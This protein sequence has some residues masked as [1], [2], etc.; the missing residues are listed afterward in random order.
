MEPGSAPFA[1]DR[2]APRPSATDTAA[3]R[4]PHADIRADTQESHVD[5]PYTRSAGQQP[6]AVARKATGCAR[7]DAPFD[8][9]GVLAAAGAG[10]LLNIAGAGFGAVAAK[11]QSA[12]SN[13]PTARYYGYAS[14]AAW[15]L[16]S[17]ATTASNHLARRAENTQ[18]AQD[19]ENTG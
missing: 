6:A 5:E 10:G 18:F 4:C 17:V 15:T 14:A 16:G 1:H 19:V 9:G 7:D 12:D 11:R 8:A 13:D 3:C 2:E